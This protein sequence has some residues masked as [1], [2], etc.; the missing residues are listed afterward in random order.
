MSNL[1]IGNDKGPINKSSV[2]PK[3]NN[4]EGNAPLKRGQKARLKKMKTKYKDQDEEDRELAMQ[5]LQ[6]I[7]LLIHFLFP[8]TFI[9]HPTS[10]KSCTNK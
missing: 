6:V 3:S 2:A 10:L 8:Q 5:I 7:S 4:V 9:E 1:A